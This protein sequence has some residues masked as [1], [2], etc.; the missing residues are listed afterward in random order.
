MPMPRVMRNQR[1][2]GRPGICSIAG[3]PSAVKSGCQY[4]WTRKPA[5]AS[6]PTRPC[7]SSA[8]RQRYTCDSRE[9]S[10]VKSPWPN[11]AYEDR[12]GVRS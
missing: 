2:G 10:F 8:S 5:A 3:P 6:M 12:S 9:H 4:S 1:A 7:V 11:A